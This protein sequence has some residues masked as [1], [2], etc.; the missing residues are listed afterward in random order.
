MSQNLFMRSPVGEHLVSNLIVFCYYKQC[1]KESFWSMSL[2]VCGYLVL[3][4]TC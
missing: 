2:D 1:C 3:W 4:G